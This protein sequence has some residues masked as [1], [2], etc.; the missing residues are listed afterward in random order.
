MLQAPAMF[1]QKTFDALRVRAD[2]P[3]LSGTMQGKPLVYLDNAATTQKPN[4]VIETIRLYYESLNA[5][6]HRGVYQLSQDATDAYEGAREKVRRFLNARDS[7]EIIYTRGTT[8]GINLVASSWGRSILK[9]G[10]EVIITAME[11]HSNIVPWQLICQ[12]TGARLRVVPINDDGEL[13]VGE[14]ANMLGGRTKIVSMVHCSNSLGTINPVKQL[15][16]L[17]RQCGAVT[18]VDGAQWVAHHPT[19]VQDIGCDFYALSGHKLFGPTGI[20]ILYGRRDLL[21]AMPPYQGGGDM[22]SSVTFEKTTWNELPYKFEAGTPNIAGAVGLGA[23]VDYLQSLDFAEIERHER[24]LLTYGTEKLKGIPGLRIVG[25][26]R[27]KSGV[28]SFMVEGISPQDVGLILDMEGVAIRTGHHCCQPVMDRFTIPGTARASF[29]MYN[30]RED[31]DALFKALVKVVGAIKK[32]PVQV[33]LSGKATPMYPDPA[34]ASPDAVAADLQ[35]TFEFLG[36]WPQ[37]YQ[38]IIEMGEKLPPMP[39][40]LK[41]EANRVHG[42]QSTV[43]VAARLKPGTADIMEFLADSDA[44]IVRGLVAMLQKLFSG[45]KVAEILA[46]DVQSYFT[47]LNLEAHLSM[48]RRNGLHGMVKRI[49]ALAA[50]VAKEQRHEGT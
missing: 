34:G 15:V 18:I 29:A 8:E 13:M 44:D 6:V 48:T 26:A 12:A 40:E 22:I 39:V 11:H 49:R 17:A 10:D 7:G 19:D 35:E 43:H 3:L 31:I 42:C 25:N 30:T 27:N 20:G 45:Q 33:S 46:F 36:D 9:P 16:G 4:S 38:F 37:R 2:F 47:K 28:I 24:D 14:F 1:N 50:E 5:N 23:A 21:D 41:T 32:K